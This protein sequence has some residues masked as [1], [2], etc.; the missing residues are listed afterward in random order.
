MTSLKEQTRRMGI[1]L[2]PGLQVKRWLSMILVGVAIISVGLAIWIDLRPV[3]RTGQLLEGLVTTLARAIPNDISGPLVLFAGLGFI[4]W[5]LS[6]AL[7]SITDVLVPKGESADLASR[8]LTHRRLSRGAKIVAIGGGTGLSTLLRGLKHYS[9]NITAVVTVADDGGSSGRLRREFGALPPGDLRNCL[10]ALADEEKLLTELF[11]YRF[12]ERTGGAQS[13]LDG[14][15]FGNLFLTVMAEIAGDWEKGL[16]AASQVLAVRGRVLPA[17]LEDVTLWAELEDGTRIEG[18][19]QI[20]GAGRRIRRIGCWPEAPKALPRV[21]EAIAEAELIV[22]APGSLY[23][24]IIPNLLVPE[25]AQALRSATVP[26]VYISN[27]VPQRGETDGFSVSDHINAME[28]V[29]GGKFI[30]TVVVQ[31][32]VEGIN[33]VPVDREAL[34]FMGLQVVGADMLEQVGNGVRHHSR[35]LARVLM[36]WYGR[37]GHQ[38]RRVS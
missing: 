3:F 36:H 14:H 32:E 13:S 29:V 21:L 23:T 37:K 27:L 20:P 28:T 12:P 24:S 8:L 34:A 11:K 2:L 5:G 17:T 10:A 4:V 22:L 33:L 31:K 9:N 19:S 6:G 26:V 15:S 7:T 38:L 30:Q 18:E 35:R 25:I 1:W 16:G